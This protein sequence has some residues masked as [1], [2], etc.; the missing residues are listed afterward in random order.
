VGNFTTAGLVSGVGGVA[1]CVLGNYTWASMGS[2]INTATEKINVVQ[3]LNGVVYVAGN[4]T[5]IDSLSLLFPSAYYGGVWYESHPELSTSGTE[6][7]SILAETNQKT[8]GLSNIEIVSIQGSVL[9]Y[10]GTAPCAPTIIFSGSGTVSYVKNG[11]T[12]KALYFN[13]F[14][15]G[16]G[17][18]ATLTLQPESLSFK[19]V[20]FGVTTTNIIAK[21]TQASNVSDFRL[22]PGANTIQVSF[23]GVVNI[24]F[25]YHNQH[26]AIDGI[27]V[28]AE[29]C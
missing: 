22:M 15:L 5:Q 24:T 13:N 20:Y 12:G 8:Y 4:F 6:I 18:V 14:T 21:I 3:V 27:A 2:G 23:T 17:D 10:D 1:L 28:N 16:A 7:I 11:T 19:N 9:T 25:Q 26:W 29:V